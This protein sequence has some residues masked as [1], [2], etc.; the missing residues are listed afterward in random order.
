MSL[1]RKSHRQFLEVIGRKFT[2]L[3]ILT[4]LFLTTLF[5]VKETHSKIQQGEAVEVIQQEKQQSLD[6][7]LTYIKSKEGF[8]ATPYRC[9]A[10]ARTIGYGDTEYMRM[11]PSTKSITEEEASSRLTL[12]V[13]DYLQK[14]GDYKVQVGNKT[15]SYAEALNPEQKASI[16]SFIYNVGDSSFAKSTLRQKIDHRVALEVKLQKEYTKNPNY[17]KRL[18]KDLKFVNVL[19]KRE[20]LKWTKIKSGKSYS[21]LDSLVVRRQEEAKMFL[22]TN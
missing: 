20:F 13:Q 16:V 14:L 5:V 1:K 8:R 6:L 19:I 2:F 22:T 7:A 3:A 11:H 15:T 12:K 18:E 4:I 21:K 10:G 9:S 17:K